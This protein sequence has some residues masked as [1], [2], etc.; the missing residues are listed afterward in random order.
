MAGLALGFKDF[1]FFS[2]LDLDDSENND[3]LISMVLFI[4]FKT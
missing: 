3:G 4:Y 1:S 2:R